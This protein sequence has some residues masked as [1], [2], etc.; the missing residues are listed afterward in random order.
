MKNE[1][2]YTYT[3]I[4]KTL[5]KEQCVYQDRIWRVGTIFLVKKELQIKIYSKELPIVEYQ[6][7]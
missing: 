6:N 4:R 2:S 3:K 5:S 7:K 1:L